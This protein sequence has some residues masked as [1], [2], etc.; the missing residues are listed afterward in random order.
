MSLHDVGA[1]GKGI[2]D[3]LKLDKPRV[4]ADCNNIVYV[5]AKATS[6]VLAVANH[7]MKWASTGIVMVPICDGVV[8]PVCKQATNQRIAT[9]EKHRI[10]A[11]VLR[12]AIRRAKWR[13]INNKLD[14]DERVALE[15]EIKKLETKCKS[16]ETQAAGKVPKNFPAELVNG[17]C[18]FK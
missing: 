10:K 6:C 9:S 15:N 5:F 7:L 14:A 3:E 1:V 11:F 8:R 16:N 12:K 18:K 17:E 4:V 13:L 2:A